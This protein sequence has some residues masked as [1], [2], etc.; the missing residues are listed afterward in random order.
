MVP[1]RLQILLVDDDS[2]D[3]K[4]IERAFSK[5]GVTRR[6]TVLKDGQEALDYLAGTGPFANRTQAQLPNTMLLDLK[7]PRVNGFEVIK[8]TKNDPRFRRLPIAVFS[9]SDEPNDVNRAY[10]LGANCYMIKPTSLPELQD[11]IAGFVKFWTNINRTPDL[12]LG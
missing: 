2:N 7:M 5:A 4:L 1:S 8:W 3:I 11:A 9:S 6:L 12:T 10:D